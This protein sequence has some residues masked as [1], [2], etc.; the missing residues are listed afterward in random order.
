MLRKEY[1]L[2]NVSSV[3]RGNQK[4][5]GILELLGKEWKV[6]QKTSLWYDACIL[7]ILCYS[8]CMV[9]KRI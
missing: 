4:A 1:L 8:S 7:A 3:P 9:F 5:L 6:K 2:E